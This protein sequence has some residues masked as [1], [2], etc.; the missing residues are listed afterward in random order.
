MPLK[1]LTPP[2]GE[3]ISVDDV[4]ANSRLDVIAT[5]DGLIGGLIATARTHLENRCNR[6]FLTQTWKLTLDAF[7]GQQSIGSAL[8][9]RPYSLPDNAI[10]LERGPVVSVSSI[11]YLDMSSTLQTMPSTDYAL[12]FSDEIA[13]ITP[14]FGKIWPIVLPQ[15]GAVVVTFIAGYGVA[16]AVPAPLIQALKLLVGHFYDNRE[17][18]GSGQEMPFSVSALIDDYIPKLI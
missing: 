12:V 4:K 5:D 1:L 16:A 13:R 17:V 8:V 9:D 6:S 10:L 15:I 3:P 18:I 7:P 2:T 11:Q 14:V